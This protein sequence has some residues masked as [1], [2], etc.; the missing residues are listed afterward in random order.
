MAQK[1]RKGLALL[2]NPFSIL[3][4]FFNSRHQHGEFQDP[5]FS[6]ISNSYKTNNFDGAGN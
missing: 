4:G 3:K 5:V 1:E 6:Q 2:Q